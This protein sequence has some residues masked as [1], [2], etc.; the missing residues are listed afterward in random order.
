MANHIGHSVRWQKQII[1]A[2]AR[3]HGIRP[4]FLWGIYGAET[5]FGRAPDTNARNYA[6]AKGPFQFTPGTAKSR[7]VLGREND[8]KAS[9]FAA[10]AELSAYK[11]YGESGM[12]AAYNGGPGAIKGH[13]YAETVN[14]I[15]KVSQL[16]KTWSPAPGGGGSYAAQAS[17]GRGPATSTSVT[18]PDQ[19]ARQQALRNYLAVRGRPGALLDLAHGMDATTTRTVSTPGPVKVRPSA[20]ARQGASG[21]AIQGGRYHPSRLKGT[22]NFE[23]ST[24][25]AWIKPALVYA[26]QHG[27]KGGVNSGFRSYQDQVRI[28]NSG[29]RPAARPGTSNHEGS[30][31]PRGA[32]DVSDAGGLARAL[33]GSPFQRALI[34][35]G[36]KDPVHFSHP[37]GG[38]Y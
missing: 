27:W 25:A 1:E 11:R 26:R 19:G 18:V 3:K 35:A 20:P 34:Y 36:G 21:P 37:H 22:A 33:R 29:V 4:A 10:A 9:A 12:A 7:G 14:Y 17:P 38:A 6:G 13:R 2:A 24:V 8:F 28:W 16:A 31:F 15:P 23:G 32:V 5:D 30:D